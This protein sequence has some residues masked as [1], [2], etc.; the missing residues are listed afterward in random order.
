MRLKDSNNWERIE[1]D[2]E[3]DLKP[4]RIDD[5][6]ESPDLKK[7]WNNLSIKKQKFLKELMDPESEGYMRPPIAYQMSHPNSSWISSKTNAYASLKNNEN[8]KAIVDKAMETYNIKIDNRIGVLSDILLGTATRTVKKVTKGGEII[9]YEET[10]SFSERMKAIDLVNQ[11][12]GVRENL[13]ASSQLAKEYAREEMK[14]LEK[15]M[16][17][18]LKHNQ[19][20]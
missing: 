18:E 11:M 19:K 5:V 6:I 7:V 1:Y 16:R 10:P 14:K 9:E 17:E 3:P 8:L 12:Q 20:K 13:K 15:E 4:R 2:D